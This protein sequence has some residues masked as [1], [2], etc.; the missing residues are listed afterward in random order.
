M[1]IFD[2]FGWFSG[3]TGKVNHY[4]LLTSFLMEFL[5]N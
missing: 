3:T 1:D 4:I 5:N 2:Y